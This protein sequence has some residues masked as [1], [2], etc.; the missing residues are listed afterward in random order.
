MQTGK[1]RNATRGTNGD[2]TCH[3]QGRVR[4]DVAFDEHVCR[5]VQ[6]LIEVQDAAEAN[7]IEALE[8]QAGDVHDRTSRNG[9]ERHVVAA[10]GYAVVPVAGVTPVGRPAATGP[11]RQ[12]RE[13]ATGRGED[14]ERGE[15]E[16]EGQG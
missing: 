3:R 13:R 8:T 11:R 16:D 14:E 7:H 10:H 15:D 4:H 12:F 1:L 5:D 2:V 6:R 9:H